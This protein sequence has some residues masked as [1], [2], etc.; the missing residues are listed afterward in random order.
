MEKKKLIK[1]VAKKAKISDAKAT[2]AYET[3]FKEGKGWR[4]EGLVKVEV[5][6]EVPVKVPGD[7][8]I[9][10]V[11]LKKEKA[12]KT[13][14]TKEKIKIVE[15]IKKVP[16]EVIKEVEK[17]KTVEIIKEVPVPVVKTVVKRVE[18]VREVPVE[19]IKEET[20][21]REVEVKVPVEKIVT[22]IV[23]KK[24]PVV[25][26]VEKKVI[27]KDTKAAD[28]WKKKC[29]AAEKACSAAMKKANAAMKDAAALKKSSVNKSELDKWKKK[30]TDLDKKC[31]SLAKVA[32][33]KPK[34]ITKTVEKKVVDKKGMM[35]WKKKYDALAKELSSTKKKLKAKPKT[36]TKTIVKEVPVEVI[37]EVEVTKQID[38]A[39]LQKMMSGMKTVEV[40]KKVVGETRRKAGVG[41]IVSRKAVSSS[42]KKSKSKSSGKKKSS[43]KDD[44]TKIE[45]IGPAIQKLIYKEG[46]TTFKALSKKDK[47]W[48][49]GVLDKGGSR[50]QM[51]DPTTWS[52]Q[53]G[54]AAKGDWDK[55]QKWQ[56]EMDG[57]RK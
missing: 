3:I 27:V 37:K 49:N 22:K 9:K 23:E 21:I 5:V 6:S 34:V 19:I 54:M 20:F 48:I 40:S 28:A 51:H 24:V 15:V 53:A 25:K 42:S 46:V 33:A 14:S 45:G 43:K 39:Q 30:C 35:A 36:I 17:I 41:K 26:T 7:T 57:G 55:L 10:K 4:K 47:N 16:V 1:Q 8:K 52:K 29:A 11:E 13:N 18:V 2:I 12:V 31:A 50:F 32:K 56:D 44:L 38:F